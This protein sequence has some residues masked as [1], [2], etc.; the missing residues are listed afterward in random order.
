M[1]NLKNQPLIDMIF[2]DCN[3]LGAVEMIIQFYGDDKK[4]AYQKWYNVRTE[5]RKNDDYRHPD[6]HYHI[7][8][9]LDSNDLPAEIVPLCQDLLE[10]SLYEQNKI[11]ESNK[12]FKKFREEKYP[13]LMLLQEPYYMFQIPH[14]YIAFYKENKAN[15][16]FEAFC[17]QGKR[18]FEYDLVECLRIRQ[19]L[20]DYLATLETI[21]SFDRISDCQRAVY[22]MQF[23]TGRRA[24]DIVF[25]TTFTAGSNPYQ[26]I[27]DKLSKNQ[28]PGTLV[29][30]LLCRFELVEHTSNLIKAYAEKIGAKPPSAALVQ[31]PPY[32]R[33]RFMNG[34][35]L[36]HTDIRNI[37]QELAFRERKSIN[38]VLP[39]ME[40]QLD[41]TRR[42]FYHSHLG[43]TAGYSLIKMT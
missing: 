24:A 18:Q 22:A 41:W 28:H 19:G 29:I 39:E 26:A 23:L 37:Y 25:Y 5:I 1:A 30:P 7:S 38:R 27:V 13:D 6:F 8:R 21:T 17:H 16:R 35:V 3:A 43:E 20:C 42:I 11:F 34:K 4:R 31:I 33:K 32:I 14:E 2:K 15:K 36:G 9:M 12:T 40:Y 10:K